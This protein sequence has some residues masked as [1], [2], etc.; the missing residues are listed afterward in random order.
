M[1]RQNGFEMDHDACVVSSCS[2]GLKR[3]VRG[4]AVHQR[5]EQFLLEGSGD[6]PVRDK[7]R[8]GLGDDKPARAGARV[9]QGQLTAVLRFW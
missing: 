3:I 8:L 5:P 6:L 9:V 2:G 1:C 4:Q 7:L